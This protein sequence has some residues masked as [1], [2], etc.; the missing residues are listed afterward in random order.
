[1]AP[2]P[3]RQVADADSLS[4]TA[5]SLRRS[6]RRDLRAY[7]ADPCGDGMTEL[8]GW[9]PT[10][11]AKVYLDESERRAAFERERTCFD[12]RRLASQAWLD[13]YHAKPHPTR[14]N[15]SPRIP[16]T[17]TKENTDAQ[18]A[19]AAFI[20]ASQEAAEVDLQ[21]NVGDAAP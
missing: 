10:T 16:F 2:R 14:F 5:R 1:M 13:D 19:E 12:E 3:F 8:Y 18:E 9:K 11:S 7:D 4:R 17:I 21:E 15:W 6:D 20:S